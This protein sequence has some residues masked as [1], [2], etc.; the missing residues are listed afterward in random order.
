[1]PPT[2][3]PPERYHTRATLAR[4]LAALGVRP[5]DALLVHCAFSR[6]GF[7]IGGPVA[8]IRALMD[9][10]GEDGLLAMPAF[11]GAGSDPVH[12]RNPP[13]RPEWLDDVRAA[14]PPFDPARTPS[15]G[16]GVLSET[17][18]T[19]PDVSRGNHPLVSF[20]AW[21]RGADEI[22]AECPLDFPFGENGPLAALEARDARVLMVG[23][24]YDTCTALHLA[25][26]RIP[27]KRTIAEG[28]MVLVDGAPRWVG[29]T[30]LMN[31]DVLFPA[32]GA[33]YDATGRAAQGTLGEAATRLSEMR[34]LVAFGAE[35]LTRHDGGS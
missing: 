27:F 16:M 33:A 1:M 31:R 17:F 34:D 28:S 14:T 24:G 5:G 2:P 32:I 9:A 10:V 13:I 12:W 11:T 30:D 23:T 8:L 4:D 18:R 29:W 15:E 35:W 19:W 3:Q 6:V 25:E 21:G 7:T 26:C 20:A 22:T